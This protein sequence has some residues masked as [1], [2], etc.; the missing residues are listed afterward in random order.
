MIRIVLPTS[1][2]RSKDDFDDTI[3][4]SAEPFVHLR[5]VLESAASRTY[6]RTDSRVGY[7]GL[8]IPQ[9]AKTA[10]RLGLPRLK[11]AGSGGLC[12]AAVRPVN[13]GPSMSLC[14]PVERCYRRMVVS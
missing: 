5:R 4:L 13:A 8:S 9:L 2:P 14:R 1:P 3:F 7:F 11:S 6:V 10:A 12:V